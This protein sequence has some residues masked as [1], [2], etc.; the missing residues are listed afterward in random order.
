M[1]SLLVVPESVAAKSKHEGTELGLV[2]S[3]QVAILMPCI[4]CIYD[5]TF[6]TAVL[7]MHCDRGRGCLMMINFNC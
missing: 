6:V 2:V 1:S 5:P 4:D 3:P 7:V